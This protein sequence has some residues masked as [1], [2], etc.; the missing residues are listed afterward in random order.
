MRILVAEG[1]CGHTSPLCYWYEPT[2]NVWSKAPWLSWRRDCAAA[3]VLDGHVYVTGGRNSD[4][5][6]ENVC[7]RLDPTIGAWTDVANLRRHRRDHG[8]RWSRQG[9]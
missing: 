7:E 4:F 3:A 1:W 2:A 5:D 8:A 6:E 9:P